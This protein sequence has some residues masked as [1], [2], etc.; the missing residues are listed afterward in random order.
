M[1][2]AALQFVL[3]HELIASAIFGPRTP[4]QVTT[5][6]EDVAHELSLT[7]GEMQLAYNSIR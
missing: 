5:A 2:V 4:A 1:T 7:T 6:I 3:T